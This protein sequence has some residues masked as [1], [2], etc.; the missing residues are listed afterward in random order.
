[1]VL[2][3]SNALQ[4]PFIWMSA[5]GVGPMSSLGWFDTPMPWIVGFGS[6][7]V[8]A[9]VCFQGW[10]SMWWKKAVALIILALA[11]TAYPLV[12]L[13]QSHIFAG[14]GV[15]PRYLLPMMVMFAGISLLPAV[16]ERIIVTRG[17][18]VVVTVLLSVAQSVALYVNLWRYVQGIAGPIQSIDTYTWWWGGL[19]PSPMAV[20]VIGSCAFAATTAFLLSRLVPTRHGKTTR[21]LVAPVEAERPDDERAPA[22]PSTA[23][24]VTAS[25]ASPDRPAADRASRLRGCV[26]I[27]V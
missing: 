26:T 1:M 10:A 15:Q 6:A 5:V 4:L 14:N 20:W 22:A 24:P 27:S 21:D 3:V 18:A 9:V 11:L 19:F 23:S 12:I 16:G 7:L 2:F 8:C 17:Q 25:A 13:Q